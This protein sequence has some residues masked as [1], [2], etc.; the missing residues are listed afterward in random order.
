MNNLDL[1]EED[2]R[3]HFH[4]MSNPVVLREKGPDMVTRAEGVYLYL[5]DGRKVMDTCSG[6]W[7][8]S[9][10]YGHRRLCEAAFRAM[11][12]LSFGH[13]IANRSNPW[14]AALS[15]KLSEITPKQFQSFLYATS[16]SE[17]NE[18]AV[19]MALHYWRLRGK[20]EK[21]VILARRG[22]Y[23]GGTLF[24]AS[25]TGQ[26]L[27]HHQ[28]GLPLEGMGHYA[29][30]TN[31]YQEGN[32]RSKEAFY[33]DLVASLERQILEI[34]PGRIAA[35]IGEP[36]IT[37]GMFIPDAGYWQGVRAL[38][39]RYDIL[40]IADEVVS[41]FGK[42][43]TMFGFESF[44]YEPDLFSMA[45]GITSGYFPISA[46]AVGSKVADVMWVDNEL[47]A[48]V[49]TNSGH[50]VGAAVALETIAVI[51]EE[52][53]VE[54]V[55]DEIGP[56]FSKR[57]HE[58]LEF[59]CVVSVRSLGVMGGIDFDASAGA[60]SASKAENDDLVDHVTR[61]MW[62]RGGIMRIGGLCL[63]MVITKEQIDEAF[64]IVKKSIAEAW[65]AR[66][67]AR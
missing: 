24:T 41:G 65:D 60:R 56:Y 37:G 61:V 16:G 53:L 44:G 54:R 23:H 18:T 6:L 45:K 19:K 10:G 11:K 21:R 35:F 4:P 42:S 32:G 17:A 30:S 2:R 64:G 67:N 34:D 7:N 13:T 25:L 51:E 57:L 55:R 22:S 14:V 66:M 38:C 26:E 12:E 9:M 39:D 15:A 28:F 47:F 43:G 50:P 46:V 1:G 58:L 36:I 8:V 33:R 52:G 59:P 31:W 48:H 20:P 3:H 5:G 63:P 62:E 40:L 49:F 29:D 27:F